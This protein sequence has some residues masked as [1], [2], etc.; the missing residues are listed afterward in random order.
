MKRMNLLTLMPLE[1]AKYT[2]RS[3]RIES[4]YTRTVTFA[5]LVSLY[6]NIRDRIVSLS[7]RVFQ[8]PFVLAPGDR[9]A[10]NSRFARVAI[11]A[12]QRT[13]QL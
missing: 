10:G 9:G 3:A 6:S 13:T 5:D 11:P 7:G 8:S 2:K 4:D 12:P 1:G